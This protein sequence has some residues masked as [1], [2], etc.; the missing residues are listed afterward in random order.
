MGSVVVMGPRDITEV[1]STEG[2]ID[3]GSVLIAPVEGIEVQ[4]QADQNSGE[5][6]AI[7]VIR[8][9]AACSIVAFAAP[10]SGGLW[11]QVRNDIAEQV[12]SADG[13]LIESEGSWGPQLITTVPTA[14][15]DGTTAMQDA[16]FLGFDG[17]RWFCRC[18]LFGEAVQSDV[19]DDVINAI[20]INRGDGAMALG[21]QL[22]MRLP[23]DPQSPPEKKRDLNP[24]VRGP[25]ITE[26]R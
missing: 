7:T 26:V 17:P 10:K 13:P 8:P 18:V 21:A 25:E 6:A 19:L 22:P 2:F 4:V 24:F 9:N 11:E 12:K 23:T 14:G 5:V 20:V 1:T 3:L 16:R 15:P